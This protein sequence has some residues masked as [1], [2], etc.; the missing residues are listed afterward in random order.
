MILTAKTCRRWTLATFVAIVS[1]TA[2]GN[3]PQVGKPAPPVTVQVLQAPAGAKATWDALRGKVVV[4]D[5]WATWCVPCRKSIPHWNQLVDDFKGK[6]VQ[7]IAITDE[8]EQVV[9]SFLKQTPIHSWVGVEG[10]GQS[11]RERYGIEGIPTTVLVNQGGVVVAVALTARLEPKDIQE[12]LNTGHSSLPPALELGTG[13]GPNEEVESVPASRPV[14]EVSV[15]LSGPLPP[16]RG[17]DSWKTWPTN[18]DAVGQYA[19]VK[20][21]VLTFFDCHEALLD[22]RTM[23]PTQWY[24]FT[25]RLPPGANQADRERAVVP[26]LRSVFGLEVHRAQAER[27]VYILKVASTN[28]PDLKLSGPNSR[29][30]GGAERGGL[31]L[32]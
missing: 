1:F 28:A 31:K 29:G 2:A 21:A 30:G 10:L 23:L 11:T 4:I 14:F 8:N 19:T 7:F 24:D 6:P 22:C 15:R 17:F 16:G 20:K 13:A 32:G 12:V 3:G 9:A 27:E 18:A 25:V 5:F 26:M